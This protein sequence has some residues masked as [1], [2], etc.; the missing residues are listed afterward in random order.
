[1]PQYQDFGVVGHL[2]P[3]QHDQVAEQAAHHQVSDR[4]EHPAM[5]SARRPARS[6]NR[7]PHDAASRTTATQANPQASHLCPVLKPHRVP[8]FNEN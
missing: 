6:N 2:A 7:A 1:V 3:G 5:I 8:A 4:E